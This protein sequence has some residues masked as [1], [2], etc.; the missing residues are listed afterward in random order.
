MSY[1]AQLDDMMFVLE[2]LCDLD[3]LSKSPGF[4]DVTPEVISTILQKAGNFAGQVLAPLSPVGDQRGLTHKGSVA[5]LWLQL[6]WESFADDFLKF[7]MFKG[8]HFDRFVILLSGE[9]L[10]VA[11]P[12]IRLIPYFPLTRILLLRPIERARWRNAIGDPT[13]MA[14]SRPS[15]SESMK[16]LISTLQSV[17]VDATNWKALNAKTPVARAR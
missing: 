7:E 4:Q 17:A 12:I 10:F 16:L 8:R 11:P 3:G 15:M 2:D 1:S 9:F 6:V 14:T 5:T 13:R